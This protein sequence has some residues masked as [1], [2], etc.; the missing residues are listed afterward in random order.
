MII[1]H[2]F[3][4][5][6]TATTSEIA[7]YTYNDCLPGQFQGSSFHIRHSRL[8]AAA[9]LGT[10]LR[11][12][13]LTNSIPSNI[14]AGPAA[15]QQPNCTAHITLPHNV[16]RLR[17]HRRYVRPIPHQHHPIPLRPNPSALLC[18]ERLL[19]RQSRMNGVEWRACDGIGIEWET[20]TEG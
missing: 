12:T 20:L 2:I 15:Q 11:Q 9:R 6:A 8:I 1:P 14:T 7:A 10:S 4:N 5:E 17:S 18:A 19:H 3:R 13:P 16:F